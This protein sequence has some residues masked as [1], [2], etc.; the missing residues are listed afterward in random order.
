MDIQWPTVRKSLPKLLTQ[1]GYK[2]GIE[3][4]VR[5]GAFSIR[6]LKKSNLDKLY[7]VDSWP[8]KDGHDITQYFT[9]IKALNRFGSR[10]IVLRM[11]FLDAFTL[12]EDAFFDF[13]HIDGCAHLGEKE[14]I[15]MWWAKLR[16]GGL[17]TGHDYNYNRQTK[18]DVDEFVE[19]HNLDLHLTT[20]HFKTWMVFKE[21]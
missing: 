11:T 8:G 21:K 4:G 1:I 13:I 2:V 5:R 15:N 6:L 3:L 9:A 7:S 17:Y 16:V 14:T 12:F 20:E 10:S 18:I 19:K